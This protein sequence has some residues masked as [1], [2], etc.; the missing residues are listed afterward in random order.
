MSTNESQSVSKLARLRLADVTE[1]NLKACLNA[2]MWGSPKKRFADWEVGDR[3]ALRIGEGIAGL[4]EVTGSPFESNEA[5]WADKPY[6]CRIPIRFLQAARPQNRLPLAQIKDALR[7]GW[8]KKYGDAPGNW[9]MGIRDQSPLP[10]A[11]SQLILDQILS[12]PNDLADLE[13]EA[14]SSSRGTMAVL[15]LSFRECLQHILQSYGRE[16]LTQPY[17]NKS[18]IWSIF[19]RT[20]SA[21]RKYP[22]VSSR[23]HL[24]CDSGAGIGNWAEVPW[25]AVLDER[26]T[27]T[28]QKGTYIV[29]LFCA[30]MSGVYLTL[31]QGIT[32]PKSQ[33]GP[34][35]A[36]EL[37][38]KKASEA[39]RELQNL[40]KGGFALDGEIRLK[41]NAQRPRDYELGTIVHKFYGVDSIPSDTG[42]NDDLD[43]L[44]DAYQSIVKKQLEP[45]NRPA[46]H[47]IF[48]ANPKLFDIESALRSLGELSWLI[49]QHAEDIRKDDH[50][51]LWRSGV[52]S[53]VLAVATVLTDPSMAE[54]PAD[55]QRFNLDQGK[56]DG[57]RLRVRLRVDAR[58][59][60]TLSRD[61][62]AEETKLSNLSILRYAQGTNFSVT[63][64]EASILKRLVAQR[65]P[66]LTVI[67]YSL[68]DAVSGLF[69][70]E[71]SL[72]RML[73][74][75]RSKKNLILQGPPGVGKTFVAKRLAYALIG[76]R[77]PHQ[78]RMIQFHQSLSYEDF[79]QGYRPSAQGFT[80][81]NGP[82]FEF[83]SQA[84][85][86]PDA[87]HVLIIDEINR[88]NL[89]KIF[90][91]ALM[92]IE[93]D[94][95][96]TDSSLKLTYSTST[97]PPFFVPPN[98]YLL[99]TMNTADRSL[100]L[101]DYALRRRFSFVTLKP[102]IESPAFRQFL[103][104]RNA[105]NEL[106][107]L[108]VDRITGLN[109][110]ISDDKANLGPG[111][112]IGHSFFCPSDQS[113]VLDTDWYRSIVETEI[114]PL[115]EEYWF[116]D[117][118]RAEQWRL[119]LL[120]PE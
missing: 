80:R 3:L 16:R 66:S 82:F 107:D 18:T 87:A 5:I 21:L 99:G 9:G 35:P 38:L 76:F 43:A 14:L 11:E 30:D 88:G 52:E 29:F 42:I 24:L 110:E 70:S 67:P 109:Q 17:G 115:L 26:E 40:S 50:V 31:N 55:E 39:R 78:L 86:S 32:E 65:E 4:A 118:E 116:D 63:D 20:K 64:E 103:L 79:M 60:P 113:I 69:L 27:T 77:D 45:D 49:N 25:V 61:V 94:K 8:R 75:W 1:E 7:S 48:Q 62:I 92:L 51:F 111:F 98:L 15:N 89:S 100:A 84:S 81:K 90:G 119:K 37:L 93:A 36:R 28:T 2:K 104:D 53:G 85:D 95:R 83:C 58:V 120:P 12:G 41:A 59:A 47:W 108:I 71:A 112:V 34:G 101:V 22:A 91:E 106:V 74:L 97:D 44:L 19:E 6:P 13:S 10:A 54:A 102:E 68:Q 46:R 33:I 117:A 72:R 56:F 73:N 96:D 57:A 114:V 23:K 105:P